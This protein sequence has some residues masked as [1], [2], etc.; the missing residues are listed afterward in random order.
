MQVILSERAY[1]S[2]MSET[3]QRAETE[4]GGTF[5]GCYENEIWYIVETIEPG[6][7]S[8]F[9]ESYFEYDREYTEQLIN[10]KAQMYKSEMTLIGLWHRH[11]YS[12]DDFSPMDDETNSN[13]A[14]LSENGA[15]SIIVNTD[16]EFRMTAYH[17]AQ[18]LKYTKI[19]YNVGDN[20]IPKHLM[21]KRKK[22]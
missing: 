5:L 19:K 13:Y 3:S 1:L 14:K 17:V 15:I 16:P 4:T 7:K 6:S 8:V 2:I 18:P 22:L 20:L 12:I 21:Q 11:P 9:K 10:K